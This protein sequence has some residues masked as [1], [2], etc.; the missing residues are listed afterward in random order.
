MND[1][2]KIDYYV[3]LVKTARERY[4]DLHPHFFSAVE[5]W[6]AARVSNITVRE[7]LQ[8]LWDAGLRTIPGGGAK[9]FYRKGYGLKF[10]PKK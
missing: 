6:N 9:K 1:D 3:Q 7:A 5:I 2:L 10:P 8:K 4:P